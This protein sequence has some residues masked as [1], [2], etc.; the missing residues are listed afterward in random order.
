MI[1]PPIIS[2]AVTNEN[3]MDL[4]KLICW[5]HGHKGHVSKLLTGTEEILA[6]L[7][8]AQELEPNSRLATSDAVLLADLLKQL[9]LNALLFE[10]LDTKVI[11][12]TEDEEK[13]EEA[14]F[15]LA[16]L[17][18][19]LSAK[20]TLLSHT[21]V[22]TSPLESPAVNTQTVMETN[23]PP[24]SSSPTS[25]NSQENQQDAKSQTHHVEH[26]S[27]TNSNSSIHQPAADPSDTHKS[28]GPNPLLKHMALR[29]T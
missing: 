22:T 8:Q 15:E 19:S 18:A 21:L 2:G 11:N 26:V 9:Q 24:P 5:R 14:V 25:S 3:W 6:R 29:S 1:L 12:A 23:A 17:Q 10:E 4:K 27:N 20:I 16:D 13:L 7:S 28:D